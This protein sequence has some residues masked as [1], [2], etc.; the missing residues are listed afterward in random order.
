MDLSKEASLVFQNA[1]AYAN[2]YK[3]EYVTPEMILL[4]ILDD[5]VF[6]EAFEECGGNLTI[7]SSNLQKYVSEYVDKIDNKEI[8]LSTGTNFVLNFAGQSAYSSGS[9]MIHVRHLVHAIWN[10]ENSYA[11]YYMEQQDITEA[12]VLQQMAIIEDENA[13][14]AISE[15]IDGSIKTKEDKAGLSLYAPCLN[16]V[17]T[18]ANPLIGREKELERTIQIL[19]RKDKNNPLHIGETGVGKT[20]ITYG[21][22]QRLKSGDVP[23]AI[24]G[25]KVFSLDLG[26]M[27]AGTQYRGDF[28]KRFKKV[29]TEIGKEEKP[30]IYI[31]EIHNLAGAGAVGEGSFDASNMLKPYLTDGHIRFIGATTFEEYKKYFEKNKGLVRRFQ[32]VEIKEPTEEETVEILNGLKAKYE[33]YHGVKY[34][35]GLMEY[36]AHMSAKFINERYLPDK[37]IDLIDEAGSYRKLHPLSQKTQTVDKTVINEILTGV[38]RVPIETVDTDDAAGLETLE[39][40]IKTRIFGQDEAVS[41]VVNAVKFSKA[42]LIEDGKPL[43]SLL[44]V[45]PTGVGK[46]E[47]ARTL[48]DELGVKLIRF[49]MSEYGEKHAVAKL[50]GSPAGYV[51][52]EEGGILT[53][54]IRKNPSCVLLLDEIEKAHA[55]IY[56]V[57]LQV[58]DYATLT[59]NQGRKAD[60]RNVVVIMTSN[61]G[62]NRL[63][64]SGIGFISES[65]D[66]SVLTEAVKNTFQPEFRNRLNKIVVF[67]SMDDDMASMVVE[68]KLKELSE[69]LQAK[70]I[71]LSADKKAKTLLK[72]KGVSQEF[73]A[74]E[75]DR[76]IRND[77][78][79]LFVDEI[80]FGKLKNGGKIKLT[81]RNKDF[82]IETSKK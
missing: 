23:D 67:N 27:L 9:D 55:D 36:A 30:I 71:T 49:D 47:I 66:E 44:F 56:N 76:V 20:A 69:Q 81:T 33:K 68:K 75:I 40:R 6:A 79:P 21:L 54:A 63:G 74:R 14:E 50:I 26:G 65:M 57:L 53:E 16:D 52:Y 25:A 37:A 70:K 35:K 41:Q 80:L 59:D 22:V 32:N 15:D 11:V 17:L 82:V 13:A 34:A 31:D 48:A 24:K 51:G 38:C 18:D 12:D 42:G 2:K 58:M 78:K 61:A 45:G 62:A 19:C 60:F 64:K 3:Y 77:V 4:M 73:G 29:L 1:I 28:E 7:L 5:D 46:T 10:L 72:T 8:L 39:E 43:A